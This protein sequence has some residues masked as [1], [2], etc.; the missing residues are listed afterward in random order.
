MRNLENGYKGYEVKFTQINKDQSNGDK[1]Y[2]DIEVEV[3]G[4]DWA[5]IRNEESKEAW[6]NYALA[7]E[8]YVSFVNLKSNNGLVYEIDTTK[9]K[10]DK[11][12]QV[13]KLQ[14]AEAGKHEFKA[15]YSDC[16]GVS[17]KDFL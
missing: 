11:I 4:L 12:T 7:L 13:I 1:H 2:I 15:F 14:V 6:D 10:D 3:T 16:Y 9:M 17:K 8:M 5:N